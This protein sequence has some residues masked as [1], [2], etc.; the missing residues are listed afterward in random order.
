MSERENQ[1]LTDISANMLRLPNVAHGAIVM[2]H[3]NGQITKN[4]HGSF[5][6]CNYSNIVNEGLRY[7]N[8][9]NIVLH[10][11][12][13][14]HFHGVKE[15]LHN[16]TKSSFIS[17][18]FGLLHFTLIQEISAVKMVVKTLKRAV[19]NMLPSR[20]HRRAKTLT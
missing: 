4:H 15:A 16:A 17:S 1:K 9:D 2:V 12:P 5:H 10:Y 18:K 8:V 14:P 11:S 13:E 20:S 7:H 6:A 3:L 19:R